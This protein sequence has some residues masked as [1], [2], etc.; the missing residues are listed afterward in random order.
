MKIKLSELR[1]VVKNILKENINKDYTHFLVDKSNNKILFGWDYSEVDSDDIRSY[2]RMDIRDMFSEKKPSELQVISRENL[3]RK[4]IN[5][6]DSSNWEN[7]K[8]N[9]QEGY[10]EETYYMFFQNIKQ[11]NEQCAKIL[12]MDK[13]KVDNI[14]KSG[15]DWAADHISTSKDDVEEVY[16]FLNQKCKEDKQYDKPT[17][18]E[19]RFMSEKDLKDIAEKYKQNIKYKAP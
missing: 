7:I 10:N 15:H 13:Q 18:I 11:I 1:S 4:G 8:E 2:T 17:G 12:E 9:I 14:L 6:F 5:P 16:N 19:G 3:K